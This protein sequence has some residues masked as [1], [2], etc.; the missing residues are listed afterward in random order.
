MSYSLTYCYGRVVH[1]GVVP[2]QRERVCRALR[3]SIN[4]TQRGNGQ[5]NSGHVD[6]GAEGTPGVGNMRPQGTET[7]A[8]DAGESLLQATLTPIDG[9]HSTPSPA[10]DGSHP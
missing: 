7:A 2:I 9:P 4:Q 3:L 5:G 10:V 1:F 6:I 8:Q